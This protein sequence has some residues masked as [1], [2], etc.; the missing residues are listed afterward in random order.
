[1]GKKRGETS[2]ERYIRAG[3]DKKGNVCTSAH[4]YPTIELKVSWGRK[5]F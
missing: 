2:K 5:K 1:M 4:T 3:R